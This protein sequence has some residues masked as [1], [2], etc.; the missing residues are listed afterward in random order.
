MFLCAMLHN[1]KSHNQHLSIADTLAQKWPKCLRFG[2]VNCGKIRKSAGTT[3]LLSQ[4]LRGNVVP[5]EPLRSVFTAP[6]PST[7]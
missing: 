5:F 3:A 1:W 7:T 4:I 2:G 6:L